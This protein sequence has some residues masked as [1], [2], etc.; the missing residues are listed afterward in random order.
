MINCLNS[1]EITKNMLRKV[2]PKCNNLF[3]FNFKHENI[4]NSNYLKGAYIKT[5][6]NTN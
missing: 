1:M 4:H 6:L 5:D 3:L 2:G